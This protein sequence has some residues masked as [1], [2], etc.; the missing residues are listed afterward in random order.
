MN[1]NY[2][3]VKHMAKEKQSAFINEA[4]DHHVAKQAGS[5]GGDRFVTVVVTR[6]GA[7]LHRAILGVAHRAAGKYVTWKAVPH[8]AGTASQ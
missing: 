4:R 6:S 8:R 1:G 3:F 7:W 2:E 5:Q